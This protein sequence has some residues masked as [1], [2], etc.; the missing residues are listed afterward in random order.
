MRL[1][2][3]DLDGTLIHASSERLF[4]RYLYEHGRLGWRQAVAFTTFAL[5]HA[6]TFRGAVLKKDKAYLAGLPQARLRDLARLFV[7]DR[8]LDTLYPPALARLERHRADCDLLLLL[9]GTPDFIVRPLCGRLGVANVI[10]TECVTRNG[11]F[12]TGIPLQ[13]PFGVDKLTLARAFADAHDVRLD[14]AVAYANAREDRFLL[15]EV[16]EAVAVRPDLRL[17]G[18]AR[19]A[20]WEILAAP[21]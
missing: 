1:V 7:K 6:F 3:F 4:A 13:H 16:G 12:S 8:L 11:V 2:I 15:A 5:R 9:T 18:L 10:A 17:R 21:T 19:R 14:H 20:G